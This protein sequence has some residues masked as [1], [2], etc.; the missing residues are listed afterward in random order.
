MA[1]YGCRCYNDKGV[2]TSRMDGRAFAV[3]V[4]AVNGK[5]PKGSRSYP[6]V[7][8]S[9]YFL[10]IVVCGSAGWADFLHASVS[11]QTVTWNSLADMSVYSGFIFV[12][13]VEK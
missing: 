10:D 13:K 12:T 11:G 9:Q 2:E 7:D 8:Y 1:T 5:Q 4:I 3:D 6:G